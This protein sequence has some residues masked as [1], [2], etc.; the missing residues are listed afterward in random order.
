MMT[1]AQRDYDT[2]DMSEADEPRAIVAHEGSPLAS[3]LRDAGWRV[4]AGWRTADGA[5]GTAWRLR[6]EYPDSDAS[7]RTR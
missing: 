5:G 2:M 6:F 7:T 3:A 4:R 1:L